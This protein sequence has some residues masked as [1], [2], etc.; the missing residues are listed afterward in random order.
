M[1]TENQTERRLLVKLI[2][3]AVLDQYMKFRGETNRSLAEKINK[4]P[5][6]IAH[7]RRGARTY[8]APTVGPAI[9]RALNAPPGSLFVAEMHGASEYARRKSA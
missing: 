8:C 2:S 3:A 5:A 9:E 1:R 4:S 6:L 7:L